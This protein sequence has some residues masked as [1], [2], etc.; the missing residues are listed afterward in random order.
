MASDR[1]GARRTGWGRWLLSALAGESRTSGNT[2]TTADSFGRRL[3]AALADEDIVPAPSPDA[4]T[5]RYAH[6]EESGPAVPGDAGWA[7]DSLPPTGAEDRPEDPTVEEE[8]VQVSAEPDTR[9][10]IVIV[11]ESS[12][13]AFNLMMVAYR[14]GYVV[15]DRVMTVDRAVAASQ[16]FRP[17]VV[18]VELTST[19]SALLEAVERISSAELAPV[20]VVLSSRALAPKPVERMATRIIAAGATGIVYSPVRSRELVTAVEF[21]RSRFANVVSLRADIEKL[22]GRSKSG[23]TPGESPRFR[24]TV[25]PDLEPLLTSHNYE[26]SVRTLPRLALIRSRLARIR[27]QEDPETLAAQYQLARTLL[28]VGR[29]DEALPHL[30]AVV[31]ARALQP[32]AQDPSTF[33][34]RYDLARVLEVLNRHD[35]ALQ[36]LEILSG[37]QEEGVSGED[38]WLLALRSLG[39]LPIFPPERRAYLRGLLWEGP[40]AERDVGDEEARQSPGGPPV[41]PNE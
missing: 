10:R 37:H 20:V 32:G 34:A 2:V 27:G 28:V 3:L 38:R 19:R 5:V 12:D 26:L 16:T 1:S 33:E 9:R 22:L 7:G 29:F 4:Y 21:A 11:S 36:Q 31:E 13:V 17:D 41:E 8:N 24:Q 6:T 15:N 30:E 23:V 18:L 35:E 25:L 14:S 39:R 40:V